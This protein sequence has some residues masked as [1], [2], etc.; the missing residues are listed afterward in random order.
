[1]ETESKKLPNNSAGRE[2][3]QIPKIFQ[4]SMVSQNQ[5]GFNRSHKKVPPLSTCLHEG[6]PLSIPGIV[7]PLCSSRLAG[8]IGIKMKL[9]IQ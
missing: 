9:S 7:I 8:E 3:L 6:Q 1:M 4:I 5:M 2:A